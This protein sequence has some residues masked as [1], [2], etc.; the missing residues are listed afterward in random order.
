MREDAEEVLSLESL[1]VQGAWG[2][3]HELG[4]N[5]QYSDWILPGTT[6]TTCNLFSVY[7][8]EE[9]SGIDR[10]LAHSA[11]D[12][13]SREARLTSYVNGGASFS[14]WSVWVALETYLQLQE[15]FGWDFYTD[16]FTDYRALQP[17]Q[18][19]NTDQE[20]IDTWAEMTSQRAGVD[21]GPFYTAWGFP[22]SAATLG[23]VDHQLLHAAR[24]DLTH[25]ATGERLGWWTAPPPDFQAVAEALGLGPA[26]AEA[27]RDP[28]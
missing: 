24:L 16:V 22:L 9:H 8:S 23:A 21:L 28:G 26:V 2:P 10:G 5:H 6:E 14:D 4:H 11:L 25:P 18:R 12:P 13:A 7:A 19:P 3:F 15:A 17:G 20:R 1:Q 27:A